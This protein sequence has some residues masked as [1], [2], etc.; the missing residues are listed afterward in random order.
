MLYR[1]LFHSV[2]YH[3]LIQ[4]SQCFHFRVVTPT[5]QLSHNLRL[6]KVIHKYDSVTE[7][8]IL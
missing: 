5:R 4:D 2:G 7:L 3:Q 1:L 6:I 8:V